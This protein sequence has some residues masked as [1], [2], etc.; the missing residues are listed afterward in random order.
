[1]KQPESRTRASVRLTAPLVR[2]VILAIAV[3]AYSLLAL[4]KSR[5]PFNEIP[6]VPVGLD[7][8]LSFAMALL[9]AFRMNR[10]YERWWEA[11]SLWGTLVNV[12]RN[13]AVKTRRLARLTEKDCQNIRNLIVAFCIGLKDHLRDDGQ[14]ARL[15]GFED[16]PNDPVHV[17]GYVVSKLYALFHQLQSTNDGFGMAELIVIDSDARELMNVCGGCE[18]IKSTPISTSWGA[19]TT[20]CIGIFLFVLPW[21]LVDDFGYWTVPISIIVAYVVIAAE[22]IARHVEQ[23]FGLLEDHLDLDSITAAIDRS[24][25]SELLPNESAN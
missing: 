21:G 22:V 23:P 5:P 9:I 4:L 6:D 13:L 3:G 7:A 25:T 15:P 2:V 8:A 14:L 1:M 12:S 16:D 24:V 19:F 10:A 20:H 18:K 11:R 17:P